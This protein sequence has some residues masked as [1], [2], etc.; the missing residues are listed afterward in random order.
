MST[1]ITDIAKAAGVSTATISRVI[2]GSSN[3]KEKTREH[4]LRVMKEFNYVPNSLARG[5]SNS[6]AFNVALLIDV[7]DSDFSNPFF[8]EVMHG[9]EAIVCTRDLSLIIASSTPS[10]K[11]KTLQRMISEKRMQAV[12]IPSS[13][14]DRKLIDKLNE[15]SFP[16]VVIGEVKDPSASATWVDINNRQGGDQAVSHLM[17][18][19]YRRIAFISG[20]REEV[21]N[22]NR[23]N[24]Y[25]DA[26]KRVA[27]DVRGDYVKEC[28]GTKSAAYSVMKEL[29]D[30]DERPDAVVCGDNV[31]SMGVMKAVHEAGF[32]IPDDLGLVAF[33][34]YP[35]AELVEPSLTTVDINVFQLGELAANSLMTLLKTPHASHIQSQVCTRIEQRESTAR[36]HSE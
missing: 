13:L 8:Y 26:I 14:A 20:S 9:I 29:L 16:F 19:G 17:D 15:L 32:T 36:S 34:R 21:F 10:D 11:L 3:I 23:V 1:S 31:I 25:Y 30:C 28:D 33:D 27:L 18:Q 5:F 6:K 12:F 22:R 24:G 35:L 4:V 2:N 7:E